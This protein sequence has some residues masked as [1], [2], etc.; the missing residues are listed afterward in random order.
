MSTL[1]VQQLHVQSVRPSHDQPVA[2]LYRSVSVMCSNAWTSKGHA[3]PQVHPTSLTSRAAEASAIDVLWR[4][5][6]QARG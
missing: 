3:S 2:L 5:S 4:L 6:V 1:K